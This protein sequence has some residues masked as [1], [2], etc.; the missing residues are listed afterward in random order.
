M[1]GSERYSKSPD[2][3]DSSDV[4]R[5]SR[6]ASTTHYRDDGA[7]DGVGSMDKEGKEG[8]E[9]DYIDNFTLSHDLR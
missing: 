5:D 2:S 7:R 4:A 6:N 8:P 9:D 3:S 1:G